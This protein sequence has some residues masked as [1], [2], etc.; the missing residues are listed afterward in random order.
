MIKTWSAEGNIAIRQEQKVKSEYAAQSAAMAVAEFIA[1]DD[2][3]NS[4][5]V[6]EIGNLS[7]GE[8]LTTKS[9]TTPLA[10]STVDVTITKNTTG[11]IEIFARGSTGSMDEMITV[12]LIGGVNPNPPTFDEMVYAGDVFNIDGVDS[13]TGEIAYGG[14]VYDQNTLVDM[15]DETAFTDDFGSVISFDNITSDERIFDEIIAPTPVYTHTGKIDKNDIDMDE[16][17]NYDGHFFEELT[18]N[19][20][21]DFIYNG[22]PLIAEEFVLIFEKATIKSDII[23]EDPDDKLVIYITEGGSLDLQTPHSI[24]NDILILSEKNTDI[25]ITAN[26]DFD[27]FVYAPY[28]D[29]NVKAPGIEFEGAIIC[30]NFNLANGAAGASF[31][32]K[33]SSLLFDLGVY[34]KSGYDIHSVRKQ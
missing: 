14:D 9:A 15:S 5:L 19:N 25:S 18:A 2:N 22:D 17:Q 29:V 32:Y 6:K 8:S 16:M 27:G 20:G 1:A 12:V 23:F 4:D 28:S 24:A 26:S 33:D 30:E 21:D 10:R 11:N 34:L 31:V 13:I 7:N 3:S